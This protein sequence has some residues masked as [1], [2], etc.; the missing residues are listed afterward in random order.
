M[1]KDALQRDPEYIKY[2]NSIRAVGYFRGEIEGSQLWDALESKALA[3]FLQSRREEYVLIPFGHCICLT[4]YSSWSDASRPSFASQVDRAIVNAGDLTP[5]QDLED[6]DDWLNVNAEDLDRVLQESMSHEAS[7]TGH[8][9]GVD[10]NSENE[11]RDT[12]HAQ[13]TKLRDLAKKV[14]AFVAGKGDV[15]GATFDE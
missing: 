11:E 8:E 10:P 5:S 14:D 12:T 4:Q 6:P 2:I 13:V 1:Q 15:E 7:R 3:V 9:M